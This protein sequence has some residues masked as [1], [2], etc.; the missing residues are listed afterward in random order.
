MLRWI[1]TKSRTRITR[2]V[3]SGTHIQGKSQR[4]QPSL[5]EVQWS[6]TGFYW[7]SPSLGYFCLL[8]ILSG[9]DHR[10]KTD[11]FTYANQTS[12]LCSLVS[13][14]VKQ[15]ASDGSQNKR[16]KPRGLGILHT[17]FNGKRERKKIYLS[18]NSSIF[19]IIKHIWD[20][21]YRV[22]WRLT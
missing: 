7:R 13:T 6:L 21:P 17:F 22:K 16:D 5:S 20:F 14:Q 10:N 18:S 15:I 8:L 2:Q 9:I 12:Q 1:M 19:F 4:P 11:L 3:D